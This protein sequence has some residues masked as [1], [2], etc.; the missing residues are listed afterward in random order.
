MFHNID[1]HLQLSS[2]CNK[3]EPKIKTILFDSPVINRRTTQY[4]LL[5]LTYPLNI[6]Q[7]PYLIFPLFGYYTETKLLLIYTMK[8]IYQLLGG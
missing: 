7:K 6:T 1:I 4:N 3:I 5:N 2:R 8:T